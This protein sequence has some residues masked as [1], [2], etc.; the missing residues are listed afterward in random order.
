MLIGM[1]FDS[2]DFDHLPEAARQA[3][4]DYLI[5]WEERFRQKKARQ[6]SWYYDPD[7]EDWAHE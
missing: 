6:G 5:E 7:C 3:D 2:K 1:G 4:D